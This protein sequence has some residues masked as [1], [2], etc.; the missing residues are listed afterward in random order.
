MAMIRSVLCGARTSLGACLPRT[1]VSWMGD[2]HD[3]YVQYISYDTCMHAVCIIRCDPETLHA[4]VYAEATKG[5]FSYQTTTS[6]LLLCSGFFY[7]TACD[8]E[9]L[10]LFLL[11]TTVRWCIYLVQKKSFFSSDSSSSCFTCKQLRTVR[12]GIFCGVCVVKT[13]SLLVVFVES[14]RLKK[15]AIFRHTDNKE[16]G[17]AIHDSFEHRARPRLL[18][19]FKVCIAVLQGEPRSFP[20]RQVPNAR[21]W[22]FHCFAWRVKSS[23]NYI[24]SI[25]HTWYL[26]HQ[27]F[28]PVLLLL[29]Q[30]YYCCTPYVDLG[31]E[32]TIHHTS[33][34]YVIQI[35]TTHYSS[36]T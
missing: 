2:T 36:T 6:R 32:V 4:H 3:R 16:F 26:V 24:N 18:S 1:A 21:G 35:R 11:F 34:P 23:K 22:C 12:C 19:V 28:P 20:T 14:V 9:R 7:A 29:Y 30:V 33:D 8:H 5:H 10:R 17:A 15:P 31:I 27:Y 25:I 13:R